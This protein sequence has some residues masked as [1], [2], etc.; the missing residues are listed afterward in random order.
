MITIIAEK[1]DMAR[2]IAAALDGIK[3]ADGTV[4]TFNQLSRY[5][6]A[7]ISIQSKNGF[8]PIKFMGQDCMV[9]HARGHLCTLWDAI[10][11]DN[12]YK[13]WKNIDLP[14][15][16]KFYGIKT[17]PASYSQ[18]K[19]VKSL[20]EKSDLIINATD[21]D[22]EGELIFSYIYEKTKCKAPYKRAYYS[23]TTEESLVEAFNNLIDSSERQ[24]VEAAGRCRAIADWLIGINCTVAAT[25]ASNAN[26]VASIGR[27]QTPTLAMIVDREKAINAFEVKTHYSPVGTFTTSEGE[28]Y[29]GENDTKFDTK[30]DG[31]SLLSSLTGKGRVVS[32]EKNSETVNQPSLYNLSLLQMDANKKFG[33]T[34]DETLNITQS[35]Y[36]KG[37]VTYPRTDSAFLP[38]DYRPTADRALSAL[39]LLPDY[40]PFLLGRP[41]VY[42]D[43]YFN[44]KKVESHYAI[45]PTH[46]TPETLSE[47]EKKIYDLI[48]RS[49]IM[50]IYP[51]A[52][53]EKV[54][55]I[56][57]D[58]GIQFVTK[59]SSVLEKGWMEVGGMPKEKL[60][61]QLN[62]GDNVIGEYE[63]KEKKTE[64]PK[65]YTD[66]S[67]LAAMV[68][69]DKDAD[70]TDYKSL[71]ELGIK[72]IGTQATRAATIELLVKRGYIERIKKSIAPTA[73]GIRLIETL[74]L[75]D[76]KSAKLTAMWEN[77][78]HEV[79]RGNES[80]KKFIAD[81]EALTRDWCKQ[82]QSQMVK[83]SLGEMSSSASGTGFKCPLC[84]NEVRKVPWGYGCS[85]YKSG[86]KFSMNSSIC[87][88]KLTDKQIESLFTKGTTAEIKGFTSKSGKKFSA[89]LVL[90]SDGKVTFN[91]D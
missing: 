43:R 16:P 79:E 19:I 29:T 91:F 83:G 38:D 30:I 52:T 60:L 48:C 6:K 57:D 49:L 65:R 13:Q 25:L 87:G 26:S 15:I 31:S 5:E 81:I 42:A 36:E 4:V 76:I 73:K 14:L 40:A 23:S 24:C 44:S 56:T 82:I 37:H 45:V 88:K 33:F 53:T 1:N 70:E 54:K 18:F 74:P 7:V 32:I 67:I 35:L 41:K 28:V 64:P 86:C 3:L 51:P 77:R 17:I 22:R 34:A 59:G 62:E 78:L 75:E 90:N 2:K 20:F 58:N 71:S 68:A 12:D 55:V 61:P 21:S 10:D 39:A 8:I 85:N 72:G 50:T 27:V 66:A 63:L 84:G 89:R 69:A 80:A 9:T 46:A 47:N 11:Y